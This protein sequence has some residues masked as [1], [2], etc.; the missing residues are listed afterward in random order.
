MEFKYH[1]FIVYICMAILCIICLMIS[2]RLPKFGDS[3]HSLN[4]ERLKNNSTHTMG[5]E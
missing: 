3:M 5:M 2:R 4:P 1:H